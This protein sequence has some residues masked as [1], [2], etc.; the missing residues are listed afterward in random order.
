M[1]LAL[2]SEE[3][4]HHMVAALTQTE[5]VFS[6]LRKCFL[7]YLYFLSCTQAAALTLEVKVSR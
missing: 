4:I 7:L 5:A 1:F 2:Y 3:H 6:S